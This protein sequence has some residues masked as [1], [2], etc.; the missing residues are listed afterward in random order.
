MTITVA[1]ANRRET[2]PPSVS[3]C[4]KRSHYSFN[5]DDTENIQEGEILDSPDYDNRMR[6]IKVLPVEYRYY[7]QVTGD[8]TDTYN[9]TQLRPIKRIKISSQP[10]SIVHAQKV[11]Q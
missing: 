3:Q 11:D 9:S 1:F 5:V 2:N 8:L 6:V 10:D 7:H 4:Q